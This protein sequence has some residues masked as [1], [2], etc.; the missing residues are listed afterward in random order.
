MKTY[1]VLTASDAWSIQKMRAKA[2][3][4]MNEKGMND[5][6]LTGG[7]IIPEDESILMASNSGTPVAMSSS[8]GVSATQAFKNIAR[9]VEGESVPFLDL[10]VKSGLMDRLSSLFGRF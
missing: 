9:R 7:G 6:L 4:L 5:V 2:E 8:N 10:T 3:N 1:Q